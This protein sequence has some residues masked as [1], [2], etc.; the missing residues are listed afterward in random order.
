MTRRSSGTND[1]SRDVAEG[2]LDTLSFPGQL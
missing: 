1:A 2:F